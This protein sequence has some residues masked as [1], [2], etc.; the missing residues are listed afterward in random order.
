MK[1]L[2]TNG[3]YT[4]DYTHSFN[5]A[6]CQAGT[7]S[8]AN[9]FNPVHAVFCAVCTFVLALFAIAILRG[10]L[11]VLLSVAIINIGIIGLIIIAG[12]NRISTAKEFCA[13]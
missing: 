2:F 6:A 9:L 4:N 8:C 1:K 12:E 10:A 5:W 13:A 11:G 7:S 3:L